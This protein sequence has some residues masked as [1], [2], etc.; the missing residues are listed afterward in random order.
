MIQ[1]Y[2]SGSY[3]PEVTRIFSRQLHGSEGAAMD[4]QRCFVVSLIVDMQTAVKEAKMCHHFLCTDTHTAYAPP[5][6]ETV[7]N[8][9]AH[10]QS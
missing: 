4:K 7:F 1:H 10:C 5:P 8:L 3:N 2:L 6:P 9:K